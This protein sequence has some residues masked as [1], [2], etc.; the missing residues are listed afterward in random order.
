M[1][2]SAPKGKGELRLSNARNTS[3]AIVIILSPKVLDTCKRSRGYR[4]NYTISYPRTSESVDGTCYVKREIVVG[5]FEYWKNVTV[6]FSLME[7]S[8]IRKIFENAI[9]TGPGSEYMWDHAHRLSATMYIEIVM[10]PLWGS[11]ENFHR[12]S[13][14]IPSP[15]PALFST[16][17]H[18]FQSRFISSRSLCF[19]SWRLQSWYW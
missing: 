15:V 1:W 14:G 13:W 10:K 7:Q 4:I 2:I 8:Q 6:T 17:L 5:S 12:Y 3:V 18:V 9:M 19:R 11:Y 16:N